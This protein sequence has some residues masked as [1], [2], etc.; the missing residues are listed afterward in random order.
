LGRGAPSRDEAVHKLAQNKCKSLSGVN[1]CL[2]Q[3][4]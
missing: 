2:Q 3:S 4:T 1:V